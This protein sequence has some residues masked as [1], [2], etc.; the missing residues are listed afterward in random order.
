MVEQAA[1]FVSDAGVRGAA[2]RNQARRTKAL[3]LA[4][5]GQVITLMSLLGLAGIY[6]RALVFTPVERL[7]GLAQKILYIHA[8]IA[9]TTLMA[10]GICGLVSVMY[11]AI[12]DL[13]L[14]RF[15]ASSAEVGVA[16]GVGTLVS[17]PLWGKPIWGAYWTWDARLS[18][19]LFTFLLFVAYLIMRGVVQDPD[20]RARFSAVIGIMGLVLV[21]FIHVTVYLFRTMHPDPVLLR[22]SGPGMPGVMLVTLLLS[23]G[24]FIAMYIG[25]V[26]HR[27]ALA[28][29]KEL[30]EEEL[31]AEGGP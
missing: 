8:P 19:T 5:V 11:L 25:L 12:K 15:A 2:K 6:V 13:R 10:F 3:G 28:I 31:L 24:V 21:P 16:F 27:Y 9:F 4:R 22:P 23:V 7:Q 30:R 1:K 29:L 20:Q 17:G 26:T 14:D 18:F